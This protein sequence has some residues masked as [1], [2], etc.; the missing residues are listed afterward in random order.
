MRF[1]VYEPDERVLYRIV[2][3]RLRPEER[4]QD[5]AASLRRIAEG[6]NLTDRRLMGF[7]FKGIDHVTKGFVKMRHPRTLAE[8]ASRVAYEGMED[9][10]VAALVQMLG[11]EW[12]T[13]IRC[14]QPV[15]QRRLR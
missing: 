14:T 3:R 15:L 4:Y 5:Y 9:K 13:P 6:S 10:N 11:F 12:P 8:A 7:F 2:Q 1:G